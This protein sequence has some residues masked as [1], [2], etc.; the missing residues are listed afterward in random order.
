MPV[1]DTGLESVIPVIFAPVH[2]VRVRFEGFHG[3]DYEQRSLA[4]YDAMLLFRSTP[5]FQTF[6]PPASPE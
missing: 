3:L 5:T 2:S 6:L 1:S 4:V